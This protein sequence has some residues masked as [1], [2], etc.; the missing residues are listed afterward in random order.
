MIRLPFL[1]LTGI[2]CGTISSDITLYAPFNWGG[3]QGN[4][5]FF[6]ET[7]ESE[8]VIS[9]HLIPKTIEPKEYRWGV[10]AFP[11][12]FDES[13]AC[14]TKNLG[15]TRHDLSR[16]HGNIVVPPENDTVQ[17]FLDKE[18]KLLG[19]GGI[20]GKSLLIRSA[21]YGEDIRSCSNIVDLGDVKT[22]EALFTSPVAGRVIFR[23]SELGDTT[24]SATLFHTGDGYNPTSRHDWKILVTDILDRTVIRRLQDR[25][26]Y[27]TILYDPNNIDD[28]NCTKENHE[29]CKAGDLVK[30]HGQIKVGS[31]NSRYSQAFFIDTNLQFASLDGYRSLY[32]A[33]FEEKNAFRIVACA[34][35]I[36]VKPREVKAVFNNDGVTGFIRFSQRYKM[37]PTIVTVSL[38]NLRGR[39]S[40]YHVHEFP[41][42]PRIFKDD[43]IC[44]SQSVGG[45]FNPFQVNRTLSPAPGTGTN[46]M[47]EVGDLSGKYGL[48][49]DGLLP[50]FHFG[51]YADFSLPLFGTYSIIGRSVVIHRPNGTRWICA[52]I[53]YPT[54]SRTAVARFVFPV[55]GE[56][57]FRQELGNPW[58]ETTV[59]GE[60]SYSDGTLNNTINHRWEI[61]VDPPG[62]DFYN[63]SKRCESVREQYNP[64]RVGLERGYNRE[65]HPANPL[66]CSL[67]DLTGK[68]RK[69]TVAARK[70]STQNKVFYT[71]VSLPLDG[72][73]GIVGRAIVLHDDL[74]PH[75]RG[76]RLACTLI[77]PFR[78][79]KA[80]VK[81]WSVATAVESN[82]TGLIQFSQET[83]HDQTYGKVDFRGM[84]GLA[85]G[86]HIHEVS[87][88]QDLEFPC[89]SD[90]VYGHFNPF[91]VNVPVGPAPGVGTVDQYEVGDL[92]GKYGLLDNK[93]VTRLDFEDS[94]LPL[95]GQ[96]GIIGRSVVIHK[97][98]RNFRWVC[99]TI[100]PDYKKEDVHEY[101]AI[102]SFD[103]LES[104]VEGYVR[105]RQLEYKDGSLSDT[106]IEVYLRHP[107]RRNRNITTGHNWDV[108]VNQVGHDA[109]QPVENVRCIAA[110]YR[111]N[112]YLSKSDD[113][114]Y[115]RDCGPANPLRCEMGDMTSRHG[116]LEV[117]GKRRVFT[118]V[119]LPLVGNYSVMGRSVVI[120]SKGG[121]NNK[122]G[123][124]NIKYDLHLVKHVTVRKHPGFTSAR[125]MEH[126]RELLN[127]SDWLVQQDAQSHHDIL[128][129]Q[130]AQL[131]VHFYGPEAH[132]LQIQFSNLI[133]LG[134]VRKRTKLGIRKITTFYKPCR[135]LNELLGEDYIAGYNISSSLLSSLF[136]IV[137]GFLWVLLLLA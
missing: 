132:K 79:I 92:S 42:P 68:S 94:N 108:F 119:N 46:D 101:K 97:K 115:K 51:V 22:A 124:A 4:V 12:A 122:L 85:S 110:G 71:D 112:P 121:S 14:S 38:K 134:S 136:T 75:H 28:T 120:F 10:Y 57:T 24:I 114:S 109:V 127:M 16:K 27:L 135:T 76:D 96:N 100:Q 118:D 49:D 44:S 98:E 13:E 102:A 83:T 137:M 72:P 86:Y 54:K 48:L 90:A 23:Q 111:W 105:L 20:W 7:P 47:Y 58:S 33:L 39:G 107:G 82:V 50:T 80:S 88:P 37:D 64:Y 55:V 63:W 11:V 8:V 15:R 77:V 3:L 103:Q 36:E 128:D 32:L 95:F 41:V 89:T 25:C 53:N 125:F 91:Q 81:T 69:I 126:M 66:R 52:N 78:G 56:V 40:G 84:A 117:G 6:Q 1:V 131:T 104:F 17:V 60:F 61:H 19:V 130:C 129:G 62:R 26:D 113:E 93:N 2:L 73:T 34:Q 65:C 106:W 70:G 67:G 99:G 21:D 87:V 43:D 31:T 133:N 123:C 74:A 5:T 30:K 18:L 45:H 9:I 116:T 35:I 29:N 59:F